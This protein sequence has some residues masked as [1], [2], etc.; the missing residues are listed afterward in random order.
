M[1]TGDFFTKGSGRCLLLLV[2]FGEFSI[3]YEIRKKI[4]KKLLTLGGVCY[5]LVK[6]C[7]LEPQSRDDVG[8]CREL[9]G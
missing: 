8:D 4:L 9:P 1:R 2:R 3:L 5:I 7:G 6:G